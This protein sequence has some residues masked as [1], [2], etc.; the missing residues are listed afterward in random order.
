MEIGLIDNNEIMVIVPLLE[1]L[2]P[3]LPVSVIIERVSEMLERGYRCAGAYHDGELIAIC[4]LWILTKVYAGRHLELDNVIVHPA[5][6][7]RG[8]GRQLVDWALAYGREKGCVTVELNCYIANEPGQRFWDK[9]GFQ[10]IGYHYQ[11]KL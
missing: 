8:V 2:N 4:G 11:I 9:T 6:R 7:V 10:K 3:G 5:C 1:M